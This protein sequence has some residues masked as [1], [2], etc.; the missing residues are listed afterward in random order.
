M[1]ISFVNSCFE[2]F[3]FKTNSFLYLIF[4]F[5]FNEIFLYLQTYYSIFLLKC[6]TVQ[7]LENIFLTFVLLKIFFVKLNITNLKF[8]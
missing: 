3:S 4:N 6:I 1:L 7:Q 5:K 8:E 2:L